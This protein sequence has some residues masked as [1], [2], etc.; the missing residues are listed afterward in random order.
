LL[1]KILKSLDRFWMVRGRPN[2]NISLGKIDGNANDPPCSF[3]LSRSLFW[4]YTPHELPHS[5]YN[6]RFST[7]TLDYR[8]LFIALNLR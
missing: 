7:A 5:P 8:R 2:R 4:L 1:L 6:Q 3:H